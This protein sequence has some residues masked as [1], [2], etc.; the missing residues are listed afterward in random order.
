MHMQMTIQ[1][2]SGYFLNGLSC[3]GH[4]HSNSWAFGINSKTSC[5]FSGGEASF[6]LVTS[7]Q[8]PSTVN[9]AHNIPVSF[10][11]LC[12]ILHLEKSLFDLVISRLIIT[13]SP[14]RIS[15]RKIHSSLNRMGPKSNSFITCEVRPNSFRNSMRQ[16]APQS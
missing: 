7:I 12:R 13:R 4:I 9:M 5:T 16:K 3:T 11:M 15:L 6:L 14:E 1:Q 8:A 10:E 2:G